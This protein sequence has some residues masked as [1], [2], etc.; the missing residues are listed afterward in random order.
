MSSFPNDSAENARTAIDVMASFVIG[1][2]PAR[3]WAKAESAMA[4]EFGAYRLIQGSITLTDLLL[5]ELEFK[6]DPPVK[7]EAILQKIA[8]E[9]YLF[10]DDD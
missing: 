1:D 5:Q 4:E 9:T 3:S 7:P 2:D 6:V 8:D 10:P